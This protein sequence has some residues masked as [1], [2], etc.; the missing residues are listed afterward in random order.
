MHPKSRGR[1]RPPKAS[2]RNISGLRNQ[3]RSRTPQESSPEPS[4]SPSKR[5][6]NQSP[7]AT[8]PDLSDLDSDDEDWFYKSIACSTGLDGTKEYGEPFADEDENDLEQLKEQAFS[9]KE[10]DDENGFDRLVD[11]AEERGDD[12][13]NE[14]WL[15][16]VTIRQKKYRE[17]HKKGAE[18]V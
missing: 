14:D 13:S 16:A 5:S 18:L 2:K 11:M 6:R 8:Y 12:P 17:A 3:K 7:D 4:P 10:M 1:G 9:E 15:P